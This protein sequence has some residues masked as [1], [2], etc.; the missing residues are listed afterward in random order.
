M[1]SC[2]AGSACSS[3][4]RVTGSKVLF[5]SEI[6]RVNRVIHKKKMNLLRKILLEVNSLYFFCTSDSFFD[7]KTIYFIVKENNSGQV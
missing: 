5:S 3:V 1:L 4:P 6:L 7:A 2:H